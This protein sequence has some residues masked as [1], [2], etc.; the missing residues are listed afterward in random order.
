MLADERAVQMLLELAH[1]APLLQLVDLDDG[2]EELEVVA[3]VARELLERVDV[4]GEAGAAE[5]DARLQELGADAVVQAHPL[6]H[7]DHVRARLL[8]DVGDLVDEG[9]LRGQEG[10]GGELDHLGRRDVGADEVARRL[11]AELGAQER[12]VELDDRIPRPVV[13]VADDDPVGAHE[14]ADGRALLEELGARH[15]AEPGLAALAEDA[16]DALPRAGRHGALHDERVAVG[17]RHRV[18]DRVHGGEVGV[19]GVGGRRADR[20]EHEARVVQRVR[21]VRGE[22]QA[23][24][25]ARDHLRQAG[26]VDGDL[27]VPQARDLR[28][29]DVDAEDVVAELGEARRADEAHVAGADDADRLAFGSAHEAREGSGRGREP[30]ASACPNGVSRRRGST[31]VRCPASGR[32]SATAAACST[33]SRHP[34]PSARR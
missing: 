23:L 34:G 7:L 21:D 33:P 16:L 13:V 27:A 30:R 28:L 5:A 32:C 8:A 4:L 10:V 3:R 12:A 1:H 6:G 20:H 22:V 2:V 18:H 14:V 15:V 17:G 11:A 26:L 31:N 9:D 29:V 24:A 19:A 25:V